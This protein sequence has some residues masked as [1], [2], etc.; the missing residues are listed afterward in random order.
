MACHSSEKRT[1]DYIE[2]EKVKAFFVGGCGCKLG[3]ENSP[4]FTLFREDEILESRSS[5]QEL[6]HDEKDMLILG[7]LMSAR[8]LRSSEK[9][10]VFFLRGRRVCRAFFL[11]FLDVSKK[12]FTSLAT[13]YDINGITPRRHGNVNRLPQNTFSEET[14]AKISKFIQNFA[15]ENGV[16]LPGRDPGRRDE[17][18]ILIP[19]YESKASIYKYYADSCQK[20][21]VVCAS[22]S[23]FCERWN[24]LFPYIKVAKPM[25]DLCWV[26]QKNNNLI[27]KSQNK[28]ES[29]KSETLHLLL[30]H[31]KISTQ[32]IEYYRNQCKE[33]KTTVE[34]NDVFEKRSPCSFNGVAHYS[35]D[36][37]QQVHYPHDPFQP[38]PI[39]FK[40]PRKCAIFGICNDGI[41]LQYNYLIDEIMNTGKGANSTISY[42]HHFLREYGMGETKGNFHAD[43]CSGTIYILPN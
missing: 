41:N 38:G 4:C 25:T 2:E 6:S 23:L 1:I 11:F 29:E 39:Y 36:Y 35:W 3:Q 37:A 33:A 16:F 20:A 17:K 28:P 32:E 9:N 26:C 13:H 22:Y 42:V 40:T 34:L 30:G 12:L 10:T 5:M 19:S 7:F 21:N 43:N 31:L 8:P 27:L 24:K 14:N 18:N 15:E